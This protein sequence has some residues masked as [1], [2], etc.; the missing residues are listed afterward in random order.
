[1]KD[2]VVLEQRGVAGVQ[3]SFQARDEDGFH[4]LADAGLVHVRVVLRGEHERVDAPGCVVVVVFDG[5]LALGVGPQ[6]GHRRGVL[7]ADARELDQD[8]V[9]ER[10]R[11]RHELGRL[12]A[13]V[14]EHHTLVAGALVF[15]GG[16]VYALGDVGALLVHCGEDGAGIGVEAVLAFRVADAADGAADDALDV[17][18]GVA[19]GDFAAYDGQARADEGFTG[20]VGRR[21]LPQEIIEDGVGNLVGHFIGVAL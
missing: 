5:E 13:G 9:G 15:L 19:G 11:E 4:I 12:V 10:Q 7:A 3:L 8:H 16:A 21:V 1:M 6:V 14:A 2:H 20:D 18:P 17:D